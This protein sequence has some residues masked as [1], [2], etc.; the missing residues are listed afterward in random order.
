MI[1][2]FYRRM[3]PYVWSHNIAT[4]TPK[5][6]TNTYIFILTRVGM[7]FN[8]SIFKNRYSKPSLHDSCKIEF[9]ITRLRLESLEQG[10]IQV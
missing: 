3:P 2:L 8:Q 5:I 6:D 10:N 7:Y 1:T 9:L 4:K